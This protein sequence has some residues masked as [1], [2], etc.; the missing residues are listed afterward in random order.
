MAAFLLRIKPQGGANTA[1]V[2][3]AL[4]A[5]IFVLRNNSS[6]NN[7]A[8]AKKQQCA[9]QKR[10]NAAT[11]FWGKA[12]AARQCFNYRVFIKIGVANG[13]FLVL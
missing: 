4:L 11:D 3:K 10:I 8:A 12:I 5:F 13:K 6:S 2:L 1:L 7:G 9:P